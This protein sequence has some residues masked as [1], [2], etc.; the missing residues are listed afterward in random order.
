MENLFFGFEQEQAD[1]TE[2]SE[3]IP[4]ISAASVTCCSDFLKLLANLPNAVVPHQ[5]API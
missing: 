1:E 4:A 5:P 3:L 2:D